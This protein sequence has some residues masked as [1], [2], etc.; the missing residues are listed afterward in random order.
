MHLKEPLGSA[1]TF[2]LFPFWP[3]FFPLPP[4]SDPL[5]LSD[6]LSS[7]CW[8]AGTLR[9]RGRTVSV[10]EGA[11]QSLSLPTVWVLWGFVVDGLGFLSGQNAVDVCLLSSVRCK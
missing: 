7:Q 10:E 9:F 2:L 8:G 5:S 6:I 4:Q 1:S 11:V 3:I